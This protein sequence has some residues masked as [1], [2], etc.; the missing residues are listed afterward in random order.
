KPALKR[1]NLTVLTEAAVAKVLFDGNRAVGVEFEHGGARRVVRA[2]REVVL[3]GGAVN[4]PQLLMLSGI[5]DRDHLA[6]HGV[7]LIQHAPDV[8]RNLIDHLAVLLGFDVPDNNLLRRRGMLTSNLGEAYG[9]VKSRP[10]LEL[11]DLELIF[12]PAPYFEEGIGDPYDRHAVVMG[13]ILLKPRSRGTITL[14]SS[15]PR[16]K[17]IIDPRYLT[18]DE[19]ADRA[20][21]MAGLRMTATIAA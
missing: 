19:G 12:A 20:A 9:I 7:D 2:R 1:G 18:D 5:G 14:R 11:P 16:S 15:D 4:S 3:C 13:P 10:D 17:P 8:G 6:E 21:L